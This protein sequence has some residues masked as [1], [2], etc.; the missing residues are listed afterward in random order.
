MVR[1]ELT[2]EEATLLLEELKERL[3]TLREEIYHSDTYEF[4]EELK[5]K[6][7]VLRNLIEKVETSLAPPDVTQ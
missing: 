7:T 5:R 4:T 2:V 6:Q 3:G 1:L